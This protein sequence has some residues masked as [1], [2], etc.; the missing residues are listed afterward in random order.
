MP[1]CEERTTRGQ[2]PAAYRFGKSDLD[3]AADDCRPQQG[4]SELATS[5]QGRSQITGTDAGCGCHHTRANQAPPPMRTG[6]LAFEHNG[7]RYFAPAKIFR[8]RGVA[9]RMGCSVDMVVTSSV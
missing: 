3:D 6:M 9:L 8:V 7:L 2:V 1:A 4:I 5:D